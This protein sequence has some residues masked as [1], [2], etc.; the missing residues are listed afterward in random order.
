MMAGTRFIEANSEYDKLTLAWWTGKLYICKRPASSFQNL[1]PI[2]HAFRREMEMLK[3]R[4]INLVVSRLG[5]SLPRESRVR[6]VAADCETGNWDPS[7]HASSVG[8]V[9][10]KLAMLQRRIKAILSLPRSLPVLSFAFHLLT[11]PV[12]VDV[13]YLRAWVTSQKEALPPRSRVAGRST[14]VFV[15][16]RS[17]E[18]FC[19]ICQL[20][21]SV[22]TGSVFPE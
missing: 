2:S 1:I 3:I 11:Q 17:L 16:Q 5:G 20:M 7:G 22:L 10:I 8:R 4:S 9:G 15:T 19:C 6:V 21:A 18:V 14:F 13:K 12:T